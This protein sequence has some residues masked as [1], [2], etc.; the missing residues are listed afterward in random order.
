MV[1]LAVLHEALSEQAKEQMLPN[2]EVTAAEIDSTLFL[3]HVS[4]SK[5][6]VLVLDLNLLGDDP[7]GYIQ[8]I[9]AIAQP[10]TIIAVYSFAKWSLIQQITAEGVRII[11]APIN[12]RLLQSSMLSMVVKEIMRTTQ[13]PSDNQSTPTKQNFKATPRRYSTQQLS[14]LQ[15]IKSAIDCECPNHIADL[16]IALSAFESYSRD[17]KNRNAQDA[18]IHAMLYQSTAEARHLMEQALSQLCDYEGIFLEDEAV[19]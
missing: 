12:M 3:D 19:S 15:Q 6:D 8:D 13:R 9:K 17:C 2:I 5:P 16:V 18:E 11:K 10:E 4:H 7:L 14:K 1:K